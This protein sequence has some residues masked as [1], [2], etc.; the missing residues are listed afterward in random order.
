MPNVSNV[1]LQIEHTAAQQAP[2]ASR[3]VAVSYQLGFTQAEVSASAN[4]QVSVS[5]L[6]DDN[7]VLPVT[8][9][10]L[11][12]A[13]VA[14]SRAE[15]ATF[16]RQQLDEDPDFEIIVDPQGHPHR[17]PSEMPDSWKARV[18]VT[19]VPGPVFGSASGVSG[20]IVGSWGPE[21]HD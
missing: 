3:H 18:L 13:R 12:A 15:K 14:V 1:Q 4:F 11:T 19:H 5:L 8:S 20:T 9:F 21:G 7:N 6:S 10:N 2:T 16:R 17:V